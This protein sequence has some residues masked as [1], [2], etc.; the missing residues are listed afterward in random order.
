MNCIKSLIAVLMLCAL[1]VSNAE[2]QNDDPPPYRDTNLSIEKRVADLLGRMTLD[3]KQLLVTGKDF[4]HTQDYERLGVP[5]LRMTD[6]AHGVTVSGDMSGPATCFPTSIGIAATW[7][8][9]L[10]YRM[11]TALGRETRARKN[12]V[13]LAPSIDMHRHPL[14]GRTYECYS[15]DPYL[16]AR[17]AVAFVK[18]VQ[19]Q[20]IG[21]TPK[22]FL[23]NN[24]Q[25]RQGTTS[26]EVGER[27]LR[28]IYLPPFRAV[29]L[30]AD[31]WSIMTSYNPVNGEHTSANKHLLLDI[32]KNEWGYKGYVVSDWRGT[33]SAS[34]AQKGLDLEMPGPG[35]FMLPDSLK[36]ALESGELKEETVNGMAGR[37]L[38]AIF[39][40]GL[41]DEGRE[42]PEGA[43]NTPEHQLL[44]REVSE[45]GIVLLKNDRGILPLK[46]ERLK[47]IA[48]IGP[49]AEK[50]RL[51]GGGSGSVTP[52]YKVSPLEG[53]SAYCGENIKLVYEEGCSIGGNLPVVYSKYLKPPGGVNADEGL[54]AEYFNN[55]TLE[56]KPV[57]ETVVKQ[58]DFSWGWHS[59][60]ENV[61]KGGY[62][63]RWTGKL[64]PPATGNYKLGLT[65]TSGGGR[66]YLDGELLIDDW[67][68]A[69][70]NF[71]SRYRSSHKSVMIDMKAGAEHD[72]RIEFRKRGNR[73]AIRLEWEIPTADNP[74]DLAVKAAEESDAAIVFAG[75]SNMI[76]GGTLDRKDI[77]LPEGQDE[78]IK[79]VLE[80]NKNTVVVLINGSPVGMEP[81]IDRAHAVL[82]AFYP[83]QEGGNAI[84][85]VLFGEVNPSGKLPDTF[86]K[87]I[88]DTPAYGNYPG[89][90]GRVYYKEG[91]FVGYRHY[92][93]KKIEPR[94]P[95]GHGL[96]YT[97]FEY[98]NI[99]IKPLDSGKFTVT[100]DVGNTGRTAGGEVVQL[101]IK[102]IECSLERPEKELRGFSKV[103]LRPGE[104]KTVT[105][106]LN[107]DALSFFDDTRMKWTV[108]P[109]AFEALAGSSSRDIR[110]RKEFVSDGKNVKL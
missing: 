104:T 68:A 30:E 21:T 9:E 3:E 96:S 67:T 105:I 5:S 51:G 20:F 2:A 84:A 71:E 66:I 59:P 32:L 80:A 49:N 46:K 87:R 29:C 108:E 44:A 86:A 24:Q 50:A 54:R 73:A 85:R 89:G 56:G 70:N 36:A 64:V 4:W 98:G 110:L 102:D 95:F 90:D 25:T 27:A 83:G 81:W 60:A 78:L 75:L 33:H 1:M 26:A 93:T 6:C 100:V 88:E 8:T 106:E 94:F 15:E 7:N 76:E 10:V 19:G 17:L 53:L 55:L 12:Q 14:N 57:T 22:T 52:F 61:K 13:L 79:A 11:G 34:A 43:L 63:I 16:T 91:I 18:G 38:R 48:V 40:M 62:S 82:E 35:K 58:L 37:I 92:D 103:F 107:H 109:G 65:T 74:L 99:R 69:Q 42:L 23:C 77:I 31:A 101:Y 47:T 97:T 72:I 45:Q 39:K 28:E 41:M